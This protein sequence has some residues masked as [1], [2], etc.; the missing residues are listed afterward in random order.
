MITV[1]VDGNIYPCQTLVNEEPI[2]NIF[3]CDDIIQ[4]LRVQKAYK[5]GYNYTLHEKCEGCSIAEICGGGCKMHNKEINKNFTCDIMKTVIL[6]M[7]KT[8]LNHEGGT[9]YAEL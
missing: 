5:I 3:S 2:C 7:I 1:G 9:E 4:A 8:I 6:Y